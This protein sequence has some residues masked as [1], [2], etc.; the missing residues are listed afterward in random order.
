M[1]YLLFFSALFLLTLTA[2]AASKFL[3]ALVLLLV[4][5]GT[6]AQSPAAVQKIVTA[7]GPALAMQIKPVA[8]ACTTAI[9]TAKT[10]PTACKSMLTKIGT[11][12]ACGAAVSAAGSKAVSSKVSSVSGN[13]AYVKC[14]FCFHDILHNRS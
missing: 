2:M 13:L 12:Q 7:C 9:A 3:C 11:N 14:T 5:T 4:V 10:C 8:T 1:H 6:M